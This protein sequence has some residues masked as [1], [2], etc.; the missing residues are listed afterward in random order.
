MESSSSEI[1][2][3]D[4]DGPGSEQDGQDE[5]DEDDEVNADTPARSRLTTR[6]A[7]LA[8]VVDSSHVALGKMLPL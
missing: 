4:G 6:Q 3:E 5:D 2:S 7:V 1:E 8:S